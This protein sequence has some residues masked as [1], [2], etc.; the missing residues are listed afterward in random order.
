MP[1]RPRGEQVVPGLPHHVVLRGNNRRKLF[2]YEPERALFVALLCDA[3]ALTGCQVHALSL[4][5]NHVHL[6]ITPPTGDALSSCVH[7]F[8]HR[9]AMKRNRVRNGSGKLFEERFLA[10][11]VGDDAYMATVT[12]YVDLNPESALVSERARAWSTLGW[13]CGDP[14]STRIPR[15]L[16]TPSSWYVGLGPC[17]AD[18]VTAYT[19]WIAECRARNAADQDA[20][21]V[22]SRRVDRP[23]G[24]SAR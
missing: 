7:R 3:V 14:E 16:W 20:R 2:S 13:H 17:V 11:P 24:S 19:A 8:A 15:S 6:L 12:A 22:D 4:L 1:R 5:L 10:K 23:D 9:Y 21:R 18:R